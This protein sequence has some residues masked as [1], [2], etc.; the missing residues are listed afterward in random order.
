MRAQP[1]HEQLC[2]AHR[3]SRLS[4]SLNDALSNPALALALSNT[5]VAIAASRIRAQKL[6]RNDF[7]RR[8][9]GDND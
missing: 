3:A 4:I 5:A 6:A 1:T 2:E 8:A 7:K 9:A